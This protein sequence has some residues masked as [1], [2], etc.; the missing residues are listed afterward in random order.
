MAANA[1]CKNNSREE[2]SGHE[3]EFWGLSVRWSI[4]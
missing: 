2:I 1:Q 4:V 3:A